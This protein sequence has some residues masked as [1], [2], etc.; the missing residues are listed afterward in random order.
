MIQCQRAVTA[1]SVN[2]TAPFELAIGCS[3][4]TVRLFDRRMLGTK[5][6]GM[7]GQRMVIIYSLLLGGFKYLVLYYRYEY[8]TGRAT[9]CLHCAYF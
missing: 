5:S 3:D 1:M 4:S 9:M 2:A 7:F 8:E 6:T